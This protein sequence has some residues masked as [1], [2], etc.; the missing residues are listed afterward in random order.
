MAVYQPAAMGDFERPF[1]VNA[2]SWIPAQFFVFEFVYRLIYQLRFVGRLYG[3]IPKL[4]IFHLG[5]I[6]SLAGF[7]A[8]A[9]LLILVFAYVNPAFV[10]RPNILSD[11]VFFMAG[12]TLSGLAFAA[13]TL[14]LLGIRS[15][16][17]SEKDRIQAQIGKQMDTARRR[18]EQRM[19]DEDYEDVTE[20][21][22]ALRAFLDL[23]AKVDSISVWPWSLNT[24][25]G[26]LSAVLLPIILWLI[27]QVLA[28]MLEL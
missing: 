20:I 24:L 22:H 1:L 7:S 17:I 27:Q 19:D 14:P 3:A 18:L 23:D 26:F 12:I 25:R 11:P 5:P 21:R 2:L 15:R 9:G 28:R 6:H 10:Y 13:F 16:L 8:R 4:D